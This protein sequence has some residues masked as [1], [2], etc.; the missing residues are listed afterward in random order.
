MS[1]FRQHFQ[2]RRMVRGQYL[3]QAVPVALGHGADPHLGMEGQKH[4]TQGRSSGA[5]LQ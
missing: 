1:G 2:K 5:D 3:S 4:H